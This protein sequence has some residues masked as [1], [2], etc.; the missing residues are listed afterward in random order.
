[1]YA[2]MAMFTQYHSRNLNFWFWVWNIY[3]T[4]LI[5]A[6]VTNDGIFIIYVWKELHVYNLFSD[7]PMHNNKE[8]SFNRTSTRQ[9]TLNIP[10]CPCFFCEAQGTL[11][12]SAE[13]SLR[14][15]SSLL[16]AYRDAIV[17]PTFY[18]LGG[19][20][21]MWQSLEPRSTPPAPR[22]SMN[23]FIWI[24]AR[25]DWLNK[26]RPGAEKLGISFFWFWGLSFSCLWLQRLQL[27]GE[28]FQVR[29]GCLRTGSRP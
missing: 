11:S 14:L 20:W 1:M 2:L 9:H 19:V 18:N 5:K 12:W 6:K 27:Q 15:L 23:E 26:N 17:A 21:Q 29:G 8:K 22:V 16:D 24:P 28:T 7:A 13:F 3:F 25:W 10:S 4:F